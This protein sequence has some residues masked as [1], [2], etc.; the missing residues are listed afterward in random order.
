M[1][2]KLWPNFFLTPRLTESIFSIANVLLRNLYCSRQK[3][4]RRH[5]NK[6]IL[7]ISNL[8]PVCVKTKNKKNTAIARGNNDLSFVLRIK[9]VTRTLH[10]RYTHSVKPTIHWP[11]AS[12]VYTRTY[13]SLR[14]NY[15]LVTRTQSHTLSTGQATLELRALSTHSDQSHHSHVPLQFSRV[16]VTQELELCL[17]PRCMSLDE[18]LLHVQFHLLL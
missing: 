9:R 8:L 14:A 3:I 16:R 5:T 15:M 11:S 18:F 2:K 6:V 13:I 4:K 10:A 17:G 7:Q 12:Q 1:Q